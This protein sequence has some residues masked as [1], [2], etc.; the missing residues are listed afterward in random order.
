MEGAHDDCE[1]GWQRLRSILRR[2]PNAAKARKALRR[3]K[4]CLSASTISLVIGQEVGCIQTKLH[5][6]KPA[7][8]C[9]VCFYRE[10]QLECAALYYD[11]EHHD[12]CNVEECLGAV[13]LIHDSRVAED[14]Q[15]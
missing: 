8:P 11:C 5:Q 1:E 4:F 3:I 7:C 9:A 6:P 10:K 15:G 2:V 12:G 14:I 13:D